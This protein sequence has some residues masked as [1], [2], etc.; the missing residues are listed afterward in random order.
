MIWTDAHTRGLHVM[1]PCEYKENVLIS[2]FK[3]SVFHPRLQYCIFRQFQNTFPKKPTEYVFF[4]NVC[5]LIFAIQ[6]LF[7][8]NTR[9]GVRTLPWE[10]VEN[11]C[12]LCRAFLF[13]SMLHTKV[14]HSPIDTHSCPILP[15]AA[16]YVI[17]ELMSNPSFKTFRGRHGPVHCSN[18]E[19]MMRKECFRRGGGGCWL[20]II[21]D[22]WCLWHPDCSMAGRN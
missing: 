18:E 20:Y 7:L 17:S 3:V 10:L 6:Q 8:V 22:R 13:W 19:I 14:T 16:I 12:R 15:S 9:S 11:T 5:Y 21:N 2:N 4:S 1:L